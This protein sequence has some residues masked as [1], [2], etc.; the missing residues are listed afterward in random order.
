MNCED[1]GEEFSRT[2]EYLKQKRTDPLHRWRCVKCDECA[3]KRVD[4]AF[5]NLPNVIDALIEDE[6]EG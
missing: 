3:V 4:Q 5:K 1:C 2:K 6:K